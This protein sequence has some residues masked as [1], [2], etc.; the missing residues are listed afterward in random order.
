MCDDRKLDNILTTNL[1]YTYSIQIHQT[2]PDISIKGETLVKD[3]FT[4]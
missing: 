2:E 1:E 3:S 4:S